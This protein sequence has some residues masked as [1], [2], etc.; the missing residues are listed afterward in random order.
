ML[1]YQGRIDLNR[2]QLPFLCLLVSEHGLNRFE[3]SKVDLVSSLRPTANLHLDSH[4][5]I[6]A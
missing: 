6:I 2:F 1:I 4:H 3:N 5:A